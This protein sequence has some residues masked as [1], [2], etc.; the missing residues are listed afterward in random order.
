VNDRGSRRERGAALV[1]VAL[2]AVLRLAAPGRTPLDPFYDAAVRSMGTSWHAFFVGAFDPSA[3]L[4]IDKPPVDLWLQVASTKL[5]GFTHA[6]LLLP[7]ALGGTLAV[8]A[9]YDLLRTLAGA[10]AALA[11]ALALAV[12]PVAVITS[13]SDTMDSVMA[14]LLVTASAVAA[15]GLRE[16][17]TARI[18]A[19][20][21]LVGLAFEVKLFE[22]LIAA[23]PLALMWWLGA[24]ATR[25]RR[26]AGLAAAGAACAAV[27]LAWL[28]ASTLLVPASSRPWAFGS[29]NGSAWSSTFVYDGW[30]RLAGLRPPPVPPP[31]QPVANRTAAQRA[32]LAQARLRTR[33]A[34]AAAQRRVPAPPGPLRLLA[35]RAH[36]GPRLGVELAAAWAALALVLVAGAWRELDRGG[37]A[38]LAALAAWLAL[39]TLLF[40]AQAGLRPR[41]LEAFDPAVAACLGAGT[42]LGLRAVGGRRGA[43]PGRVA[44]ITPATLALVLVA[45]L[46]TS[47][48]AVRGHVQD[49][50]SPGALPSAR[51]AALTAYLRANQG[52]ARYEA[53]SVAVAKAGA[54]IAR[55][56]RPVLLLTSAWGRPLVGTAELARLVAAGAVR[57]ALLGSLCTRL[58]AD[59]WAGCSPAAAWIRAH[60]VDVSRAAG[61]PH[62]GLVYALGAEARRAR[63]AAAAGS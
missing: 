1:V 15:R 26:A 19:A 34:H 22:A 31:T 40:S 53:A 62:P 37:R 24:R 3:R 27:G 48:A 45:P 33:R 42:V 57:E 10:R 21:A 61:Q 8:A 5:L 28:V 38:G 36:L 58:S 50:G 23:P 63:A 60:G 46:L 13:R 20:G 44:A 41:Y 14:G 29:T 59:R 35:G 54:V 12:L 11:G 30:D 47:V 17:R 39:G 9:L 56:G 43:R 7:A 16:G 4:A 55:D 32:L 25:R 52:G 2:A 6:G 18:V 51:L 49:S